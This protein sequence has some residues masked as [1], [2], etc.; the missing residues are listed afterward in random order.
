M[1][2]YEVATFYTM[3]KREPVGKYHIQV[4]GTTPCMVRGAED[5]MAHI[6]SKLGIFNS[7]LCLFFSEQTFTPANKFIENPEIYI[8]INPTGIKVGQ[9]SADGLY[10]LGEVECAGACVN[11]PMMAI[12]DDYYED[13]TLKDVDDILAQLAAG[14]M[15]T[16]G[17]RSG[18]L[19]LFA[20]CVIS[21]HIR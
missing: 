21:E 2:V 9:T 6:S 5:V 15:P 3:F 13:L 4:C 11:A 8:K 10:T 12:N 16:P 7:Y 1:R 17:P 19:G 14:K 18:R 20:F